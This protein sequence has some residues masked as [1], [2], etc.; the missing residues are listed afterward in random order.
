MT[1]GLMITVR[2][3]TMVGFAAKTIIEEMCCENEQN[4]RN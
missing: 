4:C 1:P 2:G 3:M